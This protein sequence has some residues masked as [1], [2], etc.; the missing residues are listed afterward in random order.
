MGTT[1]G[2]TPP[3]VARHTAAAEE[4]AA[5][6][7]W[8]EAYAHLRSAMQLLRG[9]A[10]RDELDRLRREHAEAAELA[11]RDGLTATWNRRYLD[12][13]LLALVHAPSTRPGLSVAIVDAD[14]FKQVNDTFG[15]LF[16]DR[17]LQRLVALLGG[18]PA[19]RGAFCAR[20]GGEE[21]AL[22]LPEH[23]LTAAV[24]VCE[25]V[26]ERVDHH[27]WAELDPGLRV[28]VSAGVAHSGVHP[29]EVE[30]LV[31]TADGLLYAAKAPAQRR[32]VP[33]PGHRLVRLAGEAARRRGIPRVPRA[34]TGRDRR[35]PPPCP[36][37]GGCTCR[38]A[39]AG[40]WR[41]PC[42]RPRG[43]PAAV[44]ALGRRRGAPSPASRPRGDA[45]ALVSAL[46][47]GGPHVRRARGCSSS[48]G[49][50]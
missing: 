4:L 29:P 6:G 15:H 13:R 31:G 3:A 5:D 50:P 28:T 21:F 1:T 44:P 8:Q 41:C 34:G 19:R 45:G 24:A 7:R 46:D 35:R 32:R 48:P 30:Q 43:D 12:E 36:P 14:H 20:Y 2:T 39:A 10:P 37:R 40:S 25:A 22:V 26:R 18:R 47:L 23:D 38:R 16:G 17:V 11:R 42:P 27:P 9:Y 33:R 49:C